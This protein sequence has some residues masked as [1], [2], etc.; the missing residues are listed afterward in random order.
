MPNHPHCIHISM[1]PSSHSSCLNIP[2][3]SF[4]IIFHTTSTL[5]INIT[6]PHCPMS[7]H[8]RPLPYNIKLYYHH[9]IQFPHPLRV[10]QSLCLSVTPLPSRFPQSRSFIRL[11]RLWCYNYISRIIQDQ[12]MIHILDPAS[13][14][15]TRMSIR[16]LVT[17]WKLARTVCID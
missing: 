9:H 1:P 5:L 8:R 10:A 17:I 7:Q 11:L 13:P 6:T 4:P 12:S 15:V 3:E 14:I 2:S 16:N